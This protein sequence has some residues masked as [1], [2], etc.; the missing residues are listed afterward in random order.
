MD[1]VQARKLNESKT[2]TMRWHCQK[3]PIQSAKILLTNQNKP[4][5]LSNIG[6]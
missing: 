3:K 4:L 6:I 1:L 2:G 5:M